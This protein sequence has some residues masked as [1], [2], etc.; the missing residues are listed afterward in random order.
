MAEYINFDFNV[1]TSLLSKLHTTPVLI[2][3][4]NTFNKLE[5]KNV[6][7]DNDNI[8]LDD[9]DQEIIDEE[10]YLIKK[11]TLKSTYKVDLTGDEVYE[12]YKHDS[13]IGLIIDH[14]LLPFT[15]TIFTVSNHLL[16][17]TKSYLNSSLSNTKPDN[18]LKGE[19]S[20]FLKASKNGEFLELLSKLT[21]NLYVTCDTLIEHAEYERYFNELYLVNGLKNLSGFHYFVNAGKTDRENTLGKKILLGIYSDNKIGS[22]YNLLHWLTLDVAA[23]DYKDYAGNVSP[24]R[25]PKLSKVWALNQ[26]CSYY[27]ISS[28]FEDYF[29]NILK[30][31]G[32][33]YSRNIFFNYSGENKGREIDF[34]LYLNNKIVMIECK[35]RLDKA[36]IEDTIQKTEKLYREIPSELDKDHIK[37]VMVS[38]FYN[39]NIRDHFS[40]FID[41]PPG[42]KTVDFSF[43][44]PSGEEMRC[45][46]SMELEKLKQIIKDL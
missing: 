2:K 8:S 14:Y 22:E 19:F 4:F 3:L 25:L 27:F 9:V 35:T 46:S 16:D 33:N 29:E 37:F 11:D 32:I 28:F 41:E 10:S 34:M 43:K 36:N 23:N 20:D 18:E 39:E 21:N 45:I 24:L 44:L 38:L 26:V 42:A 1:F 6:V 7:Y 17:F 13:I 30:E 40:P 15:D 5:V 31:I 12:V